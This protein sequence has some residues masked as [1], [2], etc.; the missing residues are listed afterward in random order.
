VSD[1]EE[2]D[3][4]GHEKAAEMLGYKSSSGAVYDALKP[5]RCFRVRGARHW[6]RSE[7]EKLAIERGASL[8][9]KQITGHTESLIATIERA[10]E[11]IEN[12]VDEQAKA[13]LSLIKEER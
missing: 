10:L 1:Y 3:L 13:L 6:N 5:L 8:N 4:I 7:V 12:K 11:R 2:L 9:R